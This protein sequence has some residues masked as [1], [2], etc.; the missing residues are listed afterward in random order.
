MAFTS[1]ELANIANAALDFYVRGP[2]FSQTIQSKPLYDKLRKGQ[3]T[4]PGGKGEISVPV[5]GEYTTTASGYTHDDTVTY[6]NPANIK[7][8][9][10]KWYEIHAGINITGTELKIDGISVVD[11]VTGAQKSEHSQ[12][13]LTVLTG[14]LQDKLEDMSEGWAR[15]FNEMLWLDGTQDAKAVPGILSFILDNPTAVGTTF[16]ID[17]VANPWWQNRAS[18]GITVTDPADQTLV[19]TLQKE[20][21]QLRR[22]GSPKHAFFAG[23]DFMEAF[24]KELRAKGNYTDSGW[25]NKGR[26]DAGIADIAFKGVEV[27]YD[28]TLDDLGKEK[29]GYV[30]DLNAIKLRPMEGEDMKRHNPAR[31]EDKYVYY[32]ALTWTGGLIANQ[33]NTSGVYSIA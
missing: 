23:S 29:Y 25:A 2:A 1:Q 21:R 9:V 33:L 30:L 7:R 22:Y 17:R 16:G 32:Q 8:A 4:F 10:A 24:E 6:A 3:K 26:I 20:F 19:N 31:P 14:L 15:S 18:I 11:S 5:K 13:E 12:R 27:V 28:P